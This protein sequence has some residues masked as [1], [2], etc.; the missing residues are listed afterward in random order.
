MK[1][2]STLTCD[3]ICMMGLQHRFAWFLDLTNFFSL[4]GKMQRTNF[5]PIG[6]WQSAGCYFTRTKRS[7]VQF[8]CALIYV[9]AKTSLSALQWTLL[10]SKLCNSKYCLCLLE[11]MNMNECWICCKNCKIFWTSNGIVT[12][13]SNYNVITTLPDDQCHIPLL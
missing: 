3:G 6:M 1:K 5:L 9:F 10:K 11:W 7:E 12:L 2:I 8:F 13:W 4:S